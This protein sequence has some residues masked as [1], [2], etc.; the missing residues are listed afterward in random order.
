MF[1][2]KCIQE[3]PSTSTSRHQRAHAIHFKQNFE[4]NGGWKVD[5]IIIITTIPRGTIW[6][7]HKIVRNFASETNLKDFRISFY[8]HYVRVVCKVCPTQKTTTRTNGRWTVHASKR[9]QA[10]AATT[11]AAAKTKQLK[12][13]VLRC[14]KTPSEIVSQVRTLCDC[15][16]MPQP[17]EWT[18]NVELNAELRAHLN[19]RTNMPTFGWHFVIWDS[20]L[21]DV[22]G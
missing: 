4:E 1:Q 20:S 9:T 16:T 6:I 18:A 17:T 5:R 11:A 10:L 13:N 14:E 12:M 7:T 22:H 3:E 2:R 21:V 8:G 19:V 15:A